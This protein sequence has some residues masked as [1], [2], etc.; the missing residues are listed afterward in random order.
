MSA[1]VSFHLMTA[2]HEHAP[3]GRLTMQAAVQVWADHKHVITIDLIDH[4][5][6]TLPEGTD[7]DVIENF[8]VAAGRELARRL[9]E[10]QMKAVE[11][12]LLNRRSDIAEGAGL[13]A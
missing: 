8:A 12:G 5:P 13:N 6:F 1:P 11:D 4:E 9:A 3:T 7:V 2:I 10:V